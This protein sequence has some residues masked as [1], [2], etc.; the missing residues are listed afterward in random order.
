MARL[1]EERVWMALRINLGANFCPTEIT[2]RRI[3]IVGTSACIPNRNWFPGFSSHIF[4]ISSRKKKNKTCSESVTVKYRKPIPVGYTK[5]LSKN[6]LHLCHVCM[7]YQARR[8]LRS[9]AGSTSMRQRWLML[10]RTMGKRK[11]FLLGDLVSQMAKIQ[12]I[13]AI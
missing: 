2:P 9:G 13:F 3:T 10:M 7:K 8:L 4:P 5:S 11:L 1:L 12:R 6:K